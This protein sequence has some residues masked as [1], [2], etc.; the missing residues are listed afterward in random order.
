MI[1]GILNSHDWVAGGG[2]LSDLI[3]NALAGDGVNSKS[4][5]FH[6]LRRQQSKVHLW[7]QE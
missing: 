3:N 6:S 2:D 7:S 4:K 1:E 5:N